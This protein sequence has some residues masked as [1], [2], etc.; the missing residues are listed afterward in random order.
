MQQAATLEGSRNA[1]GF[2]VGADCV[3]AR[4]TLAELQHVP[5]EVSEGFHGW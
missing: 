5:L 2:T 3:V 4:V 1:Y